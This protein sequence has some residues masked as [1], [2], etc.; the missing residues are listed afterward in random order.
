MFYRHLL[1]EKDCKILP[2]EG[3]KEKGGGDDC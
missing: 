3:L 2:E 1:M